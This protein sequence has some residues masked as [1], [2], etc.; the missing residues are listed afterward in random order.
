MDYSKT[1]VERARIKRD[2]ASN[3][4]YF[5]PRFIP[6]KLS[7]KKSDRTSTK[8]VNL[9]SNDNDEH[10][11][12]LVE[13]RFPLSLFHFYHPFPPGT[14][15]CCCLLV[16]LVCDGARRRRGCVGGGGYKAKA[17]S[18][19]HRFSALRPTT[20]QNNHFQWHPRLA[21]SEGSRTDT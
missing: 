12:W 21:V 4:V 3:E 6:Y 18:E 8:I 16:K 13:S 15:T 20:N 7:V 2:F 1:R 10:K 11:M 17:G 14:G 19:R 9:G 5:N